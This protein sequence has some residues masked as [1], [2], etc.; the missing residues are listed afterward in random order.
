MT[1]CLWSRYSVSEAI[2][3]EKGACGDNDGGGGDDDDHDAVAY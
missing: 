2:R 3:Q 1:I